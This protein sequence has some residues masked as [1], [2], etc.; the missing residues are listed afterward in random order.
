MNCNI[1]PA[2][3]DWVYCRLLNSISIQFSHYLSSIR[4]KEPAAAVRLSRFTSALF[5]VTILLH[6]VKWNPCL[7]GFSYHAAYGICPFFFCGSPA[8]AADRAPVNRCVRPDHKAV[9]PGRQECLGKWQEDFAV[10]PSA[11]HHPVSGDYSSRPTFKRLLWKTLLSSTFYQLSCPIK[12]TFSNKKT[13][14]MHSCEVHS[15][16]FEFWVIWNW[17][18]SM[19][20]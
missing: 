17:D 3:P 6:K 19:K 15:S 4:N 2:C 18:Y 20:S 8:P 16:G 1:S 9:I 7:F 10:G 5:I 13:T 12:C 11:C 14:N